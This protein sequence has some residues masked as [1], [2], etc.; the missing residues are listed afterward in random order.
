MND[1]VTD[2]ILN[3]P[4][5]QA[6]IFTEVRRLIHEAEPSI[7]E[8]IKRTYWPFFVLNGN[9]CVPNDKG[10]CERPNL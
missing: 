2:F 10:S 7:E 8:T 9:V 1:Q 4:P 5:W 6:D 3:L